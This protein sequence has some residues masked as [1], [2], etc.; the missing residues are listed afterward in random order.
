V[1]K[2]AAHHDLSRFQCG[3]HS[4]DLFLKRHALKNQAA[5]SSQTYVL[6][7]GGGVIGYYTLTFGGVTHAGSPPPVRDGMP[8]QYAIPVIVLA[9][10][11]VDK[12]EQGKSF[13]AAL[14]KDAFLRIISASEIAGLR[15]VLVH[16]LDETA[17]AFYRHFGFEDCP[18]GDLQLMIPIQDVRAAIRAAE[19][20]PGATRP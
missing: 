7:R 10:L 19:S 8:E 12:R 2:L 15:A 11:A 16:A 6:H 13:A 14:L 3:K 1:E 4:L 5:D 20:Q 9:R 17:R 18:T